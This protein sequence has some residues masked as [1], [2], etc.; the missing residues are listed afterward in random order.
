MVRELLKHTKK[1]NDLTTGNNT[2][3]SERKYLKRELTSKPLQFKQERIAKKVNRVISWI[4]LDLPPN[5]YQ[6]RVGQTLTPLMQG[7]I[8]Y[9]KLI[10]KYNIEQIRC[11]LTTRGLNK[12]FDDETN[13]TS[14]LKL[15]KTNEKDNKFFKPRTDYDSFRWNSI[16]FDHEGQPMPTNIWQLRHHYH[17]HQRSNRWFNLRL[18]KKVRK[19]RKHLFLAGVRK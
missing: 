17:H 18:A 11:E 4:N 15:L 7:K 3:T 10:K 13:W 19:N 16:H 1:I 5:Q 6:R 14:L 8:Q 9:G 2:L 12:H